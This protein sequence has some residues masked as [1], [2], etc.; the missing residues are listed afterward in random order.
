MKLLK[1]K[2]I[3]S[4]FLLLSHTVIENLT[5]TLQSSIGV[6][7]R[8]RRPDSCVGRTTIG[9]QLTNESDRGQA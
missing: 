5:H 9:L 8:D 6:Q 1:L 4:N 2:L 3:G 7:N